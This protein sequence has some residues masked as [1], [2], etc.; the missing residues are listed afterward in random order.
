MNN[1]TAGQTSQSFTVN[2]NDGR[3]HIL[4][5]VVNRDMGALLPDGSFECNR[6]ISLTVQQV[7]V[8]GHLATLVTDNG[9]LGASSEMLV[10]PQAGGGALSIVN[11][12]PGT[13]HN[14]TVR[15]FEGCY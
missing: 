1:L 11:N 13:I 6:N 5:V 9:F 3:P 7:D 2:D 4:A 15:E 10:Q 14:V 12:G 8:T